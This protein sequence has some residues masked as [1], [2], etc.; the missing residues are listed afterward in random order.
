[1]KRI[2]HDP[3]A[4]LDYGWDWT[5]WLQVGE[6]ITTYTVTS[7]IAGAVISNVQLT[8]NVVSAMIASATSSGTLTNHVTSSLGREDDRSWFLDV[9]QR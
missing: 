5:S 1:M 3:N 2:E 6:T 8:G 9:K 7:D 4:K